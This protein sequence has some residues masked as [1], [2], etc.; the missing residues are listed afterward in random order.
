MLIWRSTSP[1]ALGR[2]L[3]LMADERRPRRA[4][5]Q[6]GETA[7]GFND[8]PLVQTPEDLYR[9]SAALERE[10]AGQYARCAHLLRCQGNRQT[11]ALFDRLG[12]LETDHLHQVETWAQAAGIE[13]PPL[14]AFR[15]DP[16]EGPPAHLHG[17]TP[18][19]ALTHALVNEERAYAFYHA[20]AATTPD[21]EV[22]TV[23]ERLAAEELDH[24]L[25]LREEVRRLEAPR[26][27]S[28]APD[29]GGWHAIAV[30]V[31]LDCGRRS[32]SAAQQARRWRQQTLAGLFQGLAE[33]AETALRGLGRPTVFS[34]DGA[35]TAA[36]PA[37]LLRAE[38]ERLAATFDRIQA[39]GAQASPPVA[40]QAAITAGRLA[41][42][43]A[44]LRDTACRLRACA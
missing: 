21:P 15:W 20:I 43:L 16:I 37:H 7:M 36:S 12:A 33:E 29:L 9:L 19:Q 28:C 26:Y 32:Q 10:A 13:S 41:G 34:G 30:Q 17:I 25:L 11:A 8:R 22:R 44:R 23:A 40:A 27:Q 6:P 4:R 2:L 5:H 38:E 35:V 14:P 1:A 42:R 3:T 31:E 24:V 39:L 18:H